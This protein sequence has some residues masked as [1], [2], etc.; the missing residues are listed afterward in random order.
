MAK[1]F[2]Y[3]IAITAGEPNSIASEVLF[4]A[5]HQL[6]EQ[7]DLSFFTI[8][9]LEYLQYIQKFLN[10]T[11]PLQSITH[12]SEASLVFNQALPVLNIPMPQLK[13]W[14]ECVHLGIPS[15]ELVGLTINSLDVATNLASAKTI[16]AITTL[17]ID[18]Y[19][20]H[21]GNFKFI[22]HTEYLASKTNIQ[23]ATML[24][25]SPFSS[26][27]V[28]PTTI[29][30]SLQD[31]INNLTS[32]LIIKTIIKVNSALSK[33]LNKSLHIAVLG[34][35]PHAGEQGLMGKEELEIINPAL[36]YLRKKHD[37]NI[38]GAIPADTAFNLANNPYDVIIGMYHDQVLAPFKAMLFNQGVNVTLGL[39]FIRTSPDHGTAYDIA[40]KNIAN[41][42]SL[43]SSIILANQWQQNI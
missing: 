19:N 31:C 15:K 24:L 29:H 32:E 36:D 4:K 8:N 35:N 16:K 13:N 41:P 12:P 7:L 42:N 38:T 5:W 21:L 3:P 26:L 28:V 43:I 27:R 9:N 1:T 18:K 6:K 23:Q 34:L 25:A 11:V 40:G 30:C 22:G 39:P 2:S 37:L 14:H 20:M 17:P 10:I 33:Y